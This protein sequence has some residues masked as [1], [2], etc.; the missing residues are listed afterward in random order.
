MSKCYEYEGLFTVFGDNVSYHSS[1]EVRE[2]MAKK[3]V[4][5]VGNIPYAPELSAVEFFFAQQKKL[6]KS[7][8]LQ[9]IIDEE[10]VDVTALL[11]AAAAAVPRETITKICQLC[12]K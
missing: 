8:K 3:N 12:H 7:M 1:K 2:H 6:F 9:K 11:E 4:T 10:R 5:F